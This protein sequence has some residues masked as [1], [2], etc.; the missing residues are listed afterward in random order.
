[1]VCKTDSGSSWG[2]LLGTGPSLQV[3]QVQVRIDRWWDRWSWGW[4]TGWGGTGWGGAGET[5]IVIPIFLFF[6]SICPSFFYHY[7][8]N[9]PISLVFCFSFPFP[10]I[11]PIY[12]TCFA[13]LGFS[14]S[15]N[16]FLHSANKASLN[17]V[18]FKGK[19]AAL[20][21]FQNVPAPLICHY[22]HRSSQQVGQARLSFAALCSHC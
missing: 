16:F 3:N 10:E 20:C 13:F 14:K 9:F 15:C 5:I 19:S 4:S 17:N 2:G 6:S 18:P 12:P 7:A 1:M 11:I 21:L 8:F 22:P